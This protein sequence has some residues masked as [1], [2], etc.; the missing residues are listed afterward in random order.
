[1]TVSAQPILESERLTGQVDQAYL[2]GD[3]SEKIGSQIKNYVKNQVVDY[4]SVVLNLR[5]EYTHFSSILKRAGFTVERG[6]GTTVQG[7]IKPSDV[8]RLASL[9]IVDS[10]REPAKHLISKIESEGVAALKA[11]IAHSIG[12]TGKGVKVAVIDGG[13]DV[14]NGKLASKIAEAKSFINGKDVSGDYSRHGTAAA[15]IVI[16]VAPDVQLYLYSV[17]TDLDFVAAVNRA[18]SKQ[19]NIISSSLSFANLGPYDGSSHVSQALDN[20]R[21]AGVLPIVAAGNMAQVHWSDSFKDPESNNWLNFNGTDETNTF[22]LAQNGVVT[23]YLSW[24]R[25]WQTHQDYDLYLYRVSGD[26]LTEVSKSTN[27]QNGNYWPIEEIHYTASVGG[28]YAI[29]LLKVNADGVAKFDIFAYGASPLKYRNATGSLMNIADSKGAVTVGALYWK[30][31]DLQPFSS[32]G[33]TVDGRIKPDIMGPDGVKTT[34][35]APF[36]GTSAAAPHVAGLA[37]L[38]AGSNPTITAD[39]LA[40]ILQNTTNDIGEPGRDGVYGYGQAEARYATLD[41]SPRTVP[42]MVDGNEFSPSLL[43]RRILVDGM[44]HNISL[45]VTTTVGNNTDYVFKQWSDGSKSQSI[46]LLFDGKSHNK[47]AEFAAQDRLAVDPIDRAAQ[48]QPNEP[49]DNPSIL[50]TKSD[51]YYYYYHDDST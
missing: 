2:V 25:W 31:N 1:M 24:N 44:P 43:P 14:N 20:A 23:V 13:F 29:K 49:I 6:L 28:Q 4:I 32:R 27:R 17:R 7:R 40:D 39:K 10:I 11:D 26:N 34:G 21:K 9:S 12:Q 30:N 16:D 50:S 47:T 38:I 19:V 5:G 37:A 41:A 33:P 42:I 46:N 3:S 15:E 18:V 45:P 35:Y 22:R 48:P 36:F 51:D 8:A